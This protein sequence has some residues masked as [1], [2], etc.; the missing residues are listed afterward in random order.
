[1]EAFATDVLDPRA[2]GWSPHYR[3]QRY[4]FGVGDHR[5]VLPVL[6]KRPPPLAIFHGST[7]WAL[8]HGALQYLPSEFESNGAL[9]RYL[10]TSFL[11]E[12]AYV[13]TLMM[14]SPFALAIAGSGVTF[15]QW[16]PTSGPHPK[17]LRWADLETLAAS[18]KLFA[19]KNRRHRG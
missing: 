9:R 16:T 7:W 17:V 12:E 10:K 4:H 18:S 19:R 8:T 13:P 1:M 5:F 15:A 14:A 3:F 2:P 6:R 11:V